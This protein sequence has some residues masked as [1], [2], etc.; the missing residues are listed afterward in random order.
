MTHYPRCV[1][2]I[3]AETLQQISEAYLLHL[4]RFVIPTYAKPNSTCTHVVNKLP[5]NFLHLGF[6]FL[7]FPN[8]RII[9]CTREIKDNALSIFFQNFQAGMKY[10]SDFHDI[11]CFAREAN[12]IMAHWRA[13]LPI[14]IHEVMLNQF[15]LEVS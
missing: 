1:R 7:L 14:R 15:G 8:C 5:Q 11:A 4:K 2:N 3:S 10:A 12:R 13:V 9:H 6:L